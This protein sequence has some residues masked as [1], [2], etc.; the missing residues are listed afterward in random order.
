[1]TAK[2]STAAWTGNIWKADDWTE[3]Q[4]SQA[5]DTL[6]TSKASQLNDGGASSSAAA[7][8]D[9][10]R[11]ASSNWNVFYEQN[12]TNFFKDRHYLHK[13][14]PNEFGWLYASQ[15]NKLDDDDINDV[16]GSTDANE[17]QAHPPPNKDEIHIVEIGSGVGNAI[18]PLLEQHADLIK[19][20]TQ[21]KNNTSHHDAQISPPPQLHIHC[22]D[23][24]PT[25]IQ[26]LRQD[27]RFQIAASDGRATAHVY[28]LS[29][30]D[31]STISKNDEPQQQQQSLANS[32]DVAIL[33]FCLSAIGPHPSST[34]RRAAQHV[35]KML[36]PGGILVLRDYGRLDEG[37]FSL[38]I[39]KFIYYTSI[40]YTNLPLI[41]IFVVVAQLKSS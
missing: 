23:F 30:M 12:K 27:T 36:K 28:D 26:L 1:M 18:L 5:Q 2:E 6:Q 17:S 25:A 32:A 21:N 33:L 3:E 10:R 15:S 8:Q 16:D 11:N 7:Y 4:K 9:F 20:Y 13:A 38:D 14:F 34:L 31:P 40:S 37:T 35:R 29:S 19:Q 22:L 39:C 24:A 41:N